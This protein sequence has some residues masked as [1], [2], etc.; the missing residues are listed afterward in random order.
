M[1]NKI[2][3]ISVNRSDY[4]IQK[5]LLQLLKKDKNIDLKLLIS[6]SHLNPSLGKTKDEILLK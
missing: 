5:N 6:G 3:V 4:G 2:F 1:K